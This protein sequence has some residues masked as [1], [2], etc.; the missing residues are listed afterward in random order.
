MLYSFQSGN[1]DVDISFC[2]NVAS[3]M[4]YLKTDFIGPLT[5]YNIHFM[6][7]APNKLQDNLTIFRPFDCHVW[8]FLIASLMAVTAALIFINK[9]HATLYKE[10]V[11][12]QGSAFQ[13]KHE[14]GRE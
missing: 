14:W 4:A 11:Q 3:S 13:S 2:V 8:A 9:M 1:R 12:A 6:S 10:P 5:T 7:G